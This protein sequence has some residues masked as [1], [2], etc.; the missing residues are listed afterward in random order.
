MSETVVRD[1]DHVVPI[2]DAPVIG[3]VRTVGSPDRCGLLRRRGCCPCAPEGE[4]RENQRE[5]TEDAAAG[6]SRCYC[7]RRCGE[8]SLPARYENDEGLREIDP[9]LCSCL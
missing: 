7:D 3:A 8:R 5:P 2:D 6:H 4:E 9:N 1:Q